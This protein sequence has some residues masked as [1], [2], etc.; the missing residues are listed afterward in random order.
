MNVL[1]SIAARPGSRDA[2]VAAVLTVAGLVEVLA[3]SAGAA[4]RAVSAAAVVCATVPLAWRRTHPLLPVAAVTL[5]LL[6]QEPLGGFLVGRT[7]TPVVAIAIALYSAGRHV[8]TA[9]G[10]AA[11]AAG[12]VALS[13]IRI[14]TDPAVDDA[15][16]AVLT[17]VAVSLPLLVGRWVRGQALLQGAL[18]RTAARL[19]RDRER[20]ARH[21]AETERMRIAGDL[22][23]AI[24]GGLREIA[25]NADA[26]PDHLRAGDH[27]GARALLARSATTAREALADVRRVLGILRREGQPRRLDPPTTAL[28]LAP[29]APADGAAHELVRRDRVRLP[30]LAPA[31]VDRVLAAAVL[32]GVELE[33]AFVAPA[34]DRLVAALAGVLIAAPLLWRRRYPRLAFAGVLGAVALQNALVDLEAFPVSDIAAVVCATYAIAAYADRGA[35]VAGLVLALAGTAAHS[36]V[37]YPDGVVAALLGGVA[38]PWTLG[39]AVRAHRRLTRQGREE[40]AR[41]ERE[42]VREAAA[43]V[44]RERMR[45]AREL[46]DAVAHNISVIALQAAGA[47]GIVERD[48]SRAAEI[49][50]LIAS[51]AREALVEL[52]RLSRALDAEPDDPRPGLASVDAL[53]ERTGAAGLQVDLDVDGEPA[54]L[55]AGLDLAA[56]RIVQEA[57][58][59]AYKH[60]GAGRAPV[61]RARNGGG[62]GLVGMRER[63]AL[64][65]GTL[66][67]G[68]GP[69][70]GFVVRARLPIS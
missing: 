9:R 37:F 5:A 68:A 24:A 14:A 56:Y 69:V 43:A 57:L 47:G 23:A 58:A 8:A 16:Q 2:L 7:A 53:A 29:P 27:T 3:A 52:E 20:D 33:L 46:H 44:T 34:G 54:P 62:H 39:R 35:A 48:P 61:P 50:V 19:A 36:A 64:Y 26:L 65:G 49:A 22:Q 51:V 60:A 28:D 55:P 11:A 38:A 6:V 59:N 4:D 32:V 66:E 12:V 45:I 1:G 21:A 25:A 18:A 17:V 63:A 70:G 42:R 31:T 13:G 40:A 10:L 41:A 67:A 30:A 15:A